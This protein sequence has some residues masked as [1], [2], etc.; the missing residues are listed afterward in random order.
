MANVSFAKYHSETL[1]I[2]KIKKDPSWRQFLNFHENQWSPSQLCSVLING[3]MKGTPSKLLVMN[4][5][6]L[7][8]GPNPKKILNFSSFGS[9]CN[10]NE[11]ARTLECGKISFLSDRNQQ[12]HLGKI[13][14]SRRRNQKIFRQMFEN[15]QVVIQKITYTIWGVP[16]PSSCTAAYQSG[17]PSHNAQ[18]YQCSSSVK[19]WEAQSN[20]RCW[21]DYK[22]NISEGGEK[23]LWRKSSKC[24]KS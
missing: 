23:K 21:K 2:W 18:A 8:L 7:C 3:S 24:K 4:M 19:M 12:M 10:K 20:A 1:R 15:W 16:V 17:K 9:C 22:E 13:G 11:Q 14:K 5:I 6:I